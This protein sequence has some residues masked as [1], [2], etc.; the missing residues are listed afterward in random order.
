MI[1]LVRTNEPRPIFGVVPPPPF[2]QIRTFIA[3]WWVEWSGLLPTDQE[4]IDFV[5]PPPAVVQAEME[6]IADANMTKSDPMLIRIRAES[7]QEFRYIKALIDDRNNIAAWTVSLK[8]A[9]ALAS[10]LADLKIRVAALPTLTAASV[11]TRADH[12][13]AVRDNIVADTP[14]G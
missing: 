13:Q 8:N 3:N 6:A 7:L 10:N 11:L 1:H 14:N 9:V 2:G 4:V 12:K 5:S